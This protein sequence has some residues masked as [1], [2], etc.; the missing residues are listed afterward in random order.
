[1]LRIKYPLILMLVALAAGLPSAWAEDISALMKKAEK[2]AE[3]IALPTNTATEEGLKAARETAEKFH[4]PEFQEKVQ[5]EAQ[6]LKKEVFSDHMAPTKSRSLI[7]KQQ[8][9]PTG[10]LAGEKIY[11]FISSSMPIEAI[12]SYIEAV[13]KT[14][15]PNLIPVMRGWVNGMADT[16]TNADY[17][18]RIL[19]KDPT[20]RP[21]THH[22]CEYHRLVISLQPALFTKYGIT[23]VPAVVYVHDNI[24]Y[25]IYGDARLDYLL[26]KINS[27]AKSDTLNSLIQ[28]IRGT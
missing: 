13:V 18:G 12:R 19:E 26:E 20:C 23:Q 22:A 4:S 5:C 17:F 27:E 1:M 28:T 2:E 21:D 24:A 7:D 9:Q 6:R 10:I 15:E 3:T 25:Q 14:A 11:L 8:S 16:E